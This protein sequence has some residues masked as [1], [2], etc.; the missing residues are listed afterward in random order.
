MFAREKAAQER[1]NGMKSKENGYN[2]HLRAERFSLKQKFQAKVEMPPSSKKITLSESF[3]LLERQ[4][5]SER[6]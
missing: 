4:T 5:F 6:P 1:K 3:I 2:S